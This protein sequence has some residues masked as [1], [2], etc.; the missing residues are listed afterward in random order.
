MKSKFHI[1]HIEDNPKDA[2]LI[3]EFILAEI[4]DAEFNVVGSAD[5]LQEA[6]RSENIDLIICDYAIPGFGGENALEMVR[7]KNSELPFIF[8]SGTIG[9]ER[10]VELLRNGA[11]DYI[12]KNNLNR[13]VPS[14]KRALNEI[15]IHRMKKIAEKE[16]I[17]SR[18]FIQRIIDTS[19]NI[20]HIYDIEEKR[21]VFINKKIED[22]L[23][24]TPDEINEMKDQLVDKL[25]HPDDRKAALKNNRFFKKNPEGV[26][27][28]EFR[29]KHKNGEYRWINSA[30]TIFLYNSEGRIKQIIGTAQDI[31]ERKISEQELIK[32]KEKAETSDKMK[33]EFLAQMSHEIRTPLGAILSYVDI[34]KMDFESMDEETEQIFN[35]IDSSGKRLIRTIDLILNMSAVQTNTYI[36]EFTELK[37]F[38][39]LQKLVN[40]FTS[41]AKSNSL[42]LDLT[43]DVDENILLYADEYTFSQIFQNLIDNAIKYTEK[44]SVE[45]RIY[46]NAEEKICVDVK[47][48]G[49]GIS[50]D[51]LRNIF[52]PFSQESRGYSRK[53]E[54]NGLG[55]ALVK[56]YVELNGADINVKSKKG[57]G[58]VFTVQFNRRKE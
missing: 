22:I 7:A 38:K 17:E 15:E 28:K 51:F 40:E 54:G 46:K 37:V 8:V 29:M 52:K 10:A 13:L 6:L 34:L 11:T 1:I 45:I 16:L 55:L 21:N 49:I 4:K 32:A 19:P 35:G 3:Q 39:L 2:L 56:K 31:T 43:A 27:Q 12:L 25:I 14:I 41:L 24:Y 58:T 53:F 48:T 47:D 30:E 9:E 5:K 23:G 18:H 33:S 36:T 50:E 57:E 26:V 42:Q 20:V 44:G